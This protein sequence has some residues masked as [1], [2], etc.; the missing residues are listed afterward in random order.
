[1]VL[2]FQKLIIQEGNI[3]RQF[4]ARRKFFF[5]ARLKVRLVSNVSETSSCVPE[6]HLPGPLAT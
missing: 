2:K 4:G 6:F 5:A 1:M 3:H